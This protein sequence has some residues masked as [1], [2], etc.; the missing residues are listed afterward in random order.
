MENVPHQI[1]RLDVEF[2]ASCGSMGWEVVA[3]DRAIRNWLRVHRSAK[4][5][6]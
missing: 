5:D 3:K 4:Q 2:W 1:F 6:K